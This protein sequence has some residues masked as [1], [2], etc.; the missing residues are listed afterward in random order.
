[1]I[2]LTQFSWFASQQY[3]TTRGFI[4]VDEAYDLFQPFHCFMVRVVDLVLSNYDSTPEASKDC[5]L[6]LWK[7]CNFDGSELFRHVCETLGENVTTILSYVMYLQSL[8]HMDLFFTYS[9]MANQSCVFVNPY[10]SY[11]AFEAFN[12][13]CYV[14]LDLSENTSEDAEVHDGIIPKAI[15]CC[16]VSN[17]GG[18]TT[19]TTRPT[20]DTLCAAREEF[21]VVNPYECDYGDDALVDLIDDMYNKSFDVVDAGGQGALLEAPTMPYTKSKRLYDSFMKAVH[22][23]PATGEAYNRWLS[24]EQ[25]VVVRQLSYTLLC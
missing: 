12:K 18:Q 15:I 13:A 17:F 16:T 1:M 4:I 25:A 21:E 23:D 11:E 20:S 10:M 19:T 3:C 2:R 24:K 6:E 5:S 22:I 8:P 14:S 7:E 9:Y